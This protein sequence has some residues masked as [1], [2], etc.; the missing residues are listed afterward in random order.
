[1]LSL[2][3][4]N[5]NSMPTAFFAA[6]D[7]IAV[8]C[9]RALKDKGYKIPDDISIIGMDDMDICKITSPVLSTI[10]VFRADIASTAVKR[11]LELIK[12]DSPSCILKTQVGIE[13]VNRESVKNLNQ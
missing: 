12:S 8:G 1:M 3:E 5:K 13:L 9:V 6:N 2:I 7:I 11:L 4:N 10:R